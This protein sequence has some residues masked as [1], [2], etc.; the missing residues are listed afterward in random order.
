MPKVHDFSMDF[1]VLLPQL[2]PLLLDAL[3]DLP[4]FLGGDSPDGSASDAHDFRLLRS[5]LFSHGPSPARSSSPSSQTSG[6]SRASFS[7]LARLPNVLPHGQRRS[8][9][10]YCR[11]PEG[12]IP[13]SCVL[14]RDAR[15]RCTRHP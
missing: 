14:L 5:S 3:G 8:G 1:P 11:Q 13:A 2:L 9:G 10:E 6:A 7:A 4:A 15:Y 12:A